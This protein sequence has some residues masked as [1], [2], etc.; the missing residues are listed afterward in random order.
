MI[1]DDASLGPTTELIYRAYRFH[2]LQDENGL[3]QLLSI[4][5]PFKHFTM[6]QSI[7]R[8]RRE[9]DVDMVS[10]NSSEFDSSD[11]EDLAETFTNGPSGSKEKKTKKPKV[12]TEVDEDG[13]VW[14]VVAPKSKSK[15]K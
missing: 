5:P 12:E 4:L 2:Q 15:Q 10:G 3:K 6:G 7:N 14:Q 11:Q 9:S 1:V 13:E 8:T